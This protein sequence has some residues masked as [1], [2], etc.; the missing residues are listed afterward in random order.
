VAYPVACSP[1][2]WSVASVFLLLQSCLQVQINA[3]EKVIMLNKP[4]LPP[5]L[6]TVRAQH[7]KAGQSYFE[8]ELKR[9]KE[10]VVCHVISK[11]DDWKV[12]VTE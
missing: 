10:E 5:Y 3:I 9:H 12:V 6:D 4:H 7:I 1:Q 2:A 8:V 11:P